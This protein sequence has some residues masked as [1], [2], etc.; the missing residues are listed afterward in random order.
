MYRQSWDKAQPTCQSYP[1]AP[2]NPWFNRIKGGTAGMNWA[3]PSGCGCV[4]T[5][6]YESARLHPFVDGTHNKIARTVESHDFKA[7]EGDD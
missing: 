1:E 7:V 4:R 3:A 5:S 2:S 6:H